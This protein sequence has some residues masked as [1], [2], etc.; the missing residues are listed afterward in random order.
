VAPRRLLGDPCIVVDDFIFPKMLDDV[1]R[2]CVR[3]SGLRVP[4]CESVVG[5]A[6]P[7]RSTSWHMLELVFSV[8]GDDGDWGVKAPHQY[9]MHATGCREW[10]VDLEG[11]YSPIHPSHTSR[12][13]C[14][15][16][17]FSARNFTQFVKSWHVQPISVHLLENPR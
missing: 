8:D 3:G 11:A 13:L 2:Y 7:S 5:C 10:D 17:R 1:T 15:L 6:A 16:G 4:A 9:E 12:P 14:I